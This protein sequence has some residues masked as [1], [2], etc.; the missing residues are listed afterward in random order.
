[1]ISANTPLDAQR[2]ALQAS[3]Q[4]QAQF[5]FWW[6]DVI[7]IGMRELLTQKY[8]LGGRLIGTYYRSLESNLLR[9]S[10]RVIAISDVFL[11]IARAWGI[12]RRNMAVLPNWA[13]IEDISVLPRDNRWAAAHG[14]QGK[15][16]LLYAGILGL[17]HDPQM[18]VSLAKFFQET[19]DVAVVVVSEGIGAD[20]LK[21]RKQDFRLE[22]LYILPFQ[23]YEEFPAML[24][25]ADVLLV[26]LN[27]G[28]GAYSV[29]SKVLSYLCA[30]RPVLI[31]AAVDNPA[32]REAVEFDFGRVAE[33]NQPDSLCELAREFYDNE[34]L[35][36]CC[37]K[38]AR[39]YAESAF[40]IKKI[41]NQFSE[42]LQPG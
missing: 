17:K 42:L 8:G 27:S 29:P 40:D 19:A 15:F 2:M 16:V 12:P 20:W 1:V 32:A 34:K 11:P 14:L 9:R 38:N 35:R 10:D 37:G 41:A 24:A 21:K 3:Q 5:I 33:P 18:F 30:G 23:P 4:L 36:I 22:N 39:A 31:S 6:Q 26:S 25:S 13:P 28:A 7:S